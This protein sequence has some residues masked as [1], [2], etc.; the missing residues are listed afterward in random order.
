MYLGF[1]STAYWKGTRTDESLQKIVYGW[2]ILCHS[3]TLDGE[4]QI[5]IFLIFVAL[6]EICD[7]ELVCLIWSTYTAIYW[8]YAW[9]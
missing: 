6:L 7:L 1:N 8:G 2:N 5:K 4:T 3:E 9:Y